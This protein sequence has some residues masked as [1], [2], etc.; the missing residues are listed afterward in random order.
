MFFLW[1]HAAAADATLRLNKPF[2]LNDDLC[3][4]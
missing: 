4:I 1:F 2:V 3:P